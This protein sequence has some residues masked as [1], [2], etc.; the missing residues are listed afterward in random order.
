[1][2]PTPPQRRAVLAALAAGLAAPAWA[3]GDKPVRFILPN[4]PGSGVDA[5]TRA[6]QAALATALGRPIIVDNQAGAGGVVG[7]Q[8]LARAPA[9]GS[10]L[11]VVSNN[12]VI[13]PSVMKALPFNMP[14]DFTPIAVVGYT[15]VVLVVNPRVKAGNAKE[16]V[17][18]LKAR[19]GE[20]NYAS[21]GNG[22]IL[23][24]ASELFLEETGTKAKHIPYKG[25]YSTYGLPM[26]T[27]ALLCA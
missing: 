5:I 25:V 17:A 22:T 12:V 4:A 26:K 6:A 2:H 20:L 18:L 27:E 9:D 14:A 15:P 11:A 1:M 19:P 10:A 21:G 23:H 24:L 16:F 3:Q 7:L 8:A 13:L